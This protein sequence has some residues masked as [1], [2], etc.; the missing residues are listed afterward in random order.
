MFT[1]R[2]QNVGSGPIGLKGIGFRP[3]RRE[4]GGSSPTG[5]WRRRGVAIAAA[6]PIFVAGAC[7]SGGR[8]TP[9]TS[10]PTGPTTSTTSATAGTGTGWNWL[11][12]TSPSLAAL[13]NSPAT[14]LA[15]VLAPVQQSSPWVAAGSR[16]AGAG[17][18]TATAWTSPDAHAWTADP[19]TGSGVFSEANA[20]ATW[21][22]GAV[23]VGSIGQGANQHA[24]A[25]VSA[26]PGVP[27]SAVPVSDSASGLGAG[28]NSS[29]PGASGP[30][31]L[32][33][34]T[35]GN[36]GYF[37]IGT[38]GGQP[39]VWYST[40]GLQWSLSVQATR[41][42]DALSSPRINTL[43]STSG[44]V[45]AAG[46]VGDGPATDAAV[47]STDDGLNWRA[48]QPP[49]GSFSGEGDH[50]ITGL[51]QLGSGQAAP[52]GLVAVGGLDS[53]GVWT[54]V[55]WISPDGVT[56]SQPSA[57]FPEDGTV[58]GVA[59]AV[60]AVPNLAGASEFLA[61]G[62]NDSVQQ[63]W[64]SPD[65]MR[66]ER[67]PLPGQSASS[68]G[69]RANLVASSGSL[70]AI[71]D[72]D[73][74]QAH[75]IVRAGSNWTEPSANPST[76]GP[77]G[78]VEDATGMQTLKGNLVLTIKTS[79]APQAIGNVKVSTVSLSSADGVNWSNPGAPGSAITAT[80]QG[81]PAATAV[82]LLGATW[83]AAGNAAS[84]SGSYGPAVG[85]TSSDGS[86]WTSAG[87]LDPQPGVLTE[88]PSG[89]CAGSG[90]AVVVGAAEQPR[91][92]TSAAAWY[93]LTGTHWKAAAMVA[94]PAAGA[95]EW[96]VG[97]TQTGSGFVAYGATGASGGL[98]PA[99][100]ASPDG[101]RW[102]LLDTSN[103]G[104]A[105]PAPITSL[106]VSGSRWI[107]VAGSGSPE[108]L[109]IS[110]HLPYGTA[111]LY[112]PSVS[113]A[114]VWIS[115][116]AGSSWQRVD[117]GDPVWESATAASVERAGFAGSTAVVAGV[118]DG[119][120]VV[121]TGTPAL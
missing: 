84:Q 30:S 41:F 28:A 92:G 47:W 8:A 64:K 53:G 85:W 97:C 23:V 72:K 90:T 24:E 116:D 117:S 99:V 114:A 42:F 13:N 86:N 6:F 115:V 120:V 107:A 31:E 102:T 71:G 39:A 19:L 54:P 17:N 93:S 105:A 83:F 113:G 21:K 27:F 89:V 70:I 51:A 91:S 48:A 7:S 9:P 121:W 22:S 35:A 46:S 58:G 100:W 36:L 111:L 34:V 33:L 37:S 77:V 60:T 38:L 79:S 57:S 78:P 2:R 112:P 12:D 15:A 4:P 87:T 26:G 59:T 69:W 32:R 44:R 1:R 62:G 101:T 67:I 55:S 63:A 40:N 68:D 11:V 94:S 80:V 106:G 18:S 5:R 61:T 76:F 29:G 119:R 52:V 20:A 88:T 82:G 65:G 110:A 45:Y 103:L 75:L 109:T 104:H 118:V 43:L 25:W 96:M 10:N 66:W 73:T 108:S 74:G 50:A 81:P 14:T 56:W 49:Q 3:F 98:V 95:L 16:S